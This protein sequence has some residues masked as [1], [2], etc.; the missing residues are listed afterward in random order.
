MA[1]LQ[2]SPSEPL[3]SNLNDTGRLAVVIDC[4]LGLTEVGPNS[5]RTPVNVSSGNKAN[6]AAAAVLPGV[7]GKTTYLSGFEVS[8][9]G[10]TAGLPVTVTASDG[11]QTLSYTYSAAAGALVANQPLIVFFPFPIPASLPNTAW[12]VTCPAL[13]AGNTNNTVNAHGFQQ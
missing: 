10:A 3:L 8:G 2:P 7:A 5:L 6:A 11:T 9:S 13:G 4:L 12:T 1:A